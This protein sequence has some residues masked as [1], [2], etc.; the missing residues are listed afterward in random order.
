MAEDCDYY[1]KNGICSLDKAPCDID[2]YLSCGLF[3]EKVRVR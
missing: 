3:F 2:C 1:N